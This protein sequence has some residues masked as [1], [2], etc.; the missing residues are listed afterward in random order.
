VSYD[1]GAV[2]E[3]IRRIVMDRPATRLQ[4]VCIK[5]GVERHTARRCLRRVFRASFRQL[6]NECLRIRHEALRRQGATLKEIAF[7]LGYSSTDVMSR[8]RKNAT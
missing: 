7:Q 5:I 8:R 3:S 1:V 2:A 6:Q 4:D